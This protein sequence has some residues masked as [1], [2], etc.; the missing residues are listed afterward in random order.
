MLCEMDWF[1]FMIKK[2]NTETQTTPYVPNH[3][4]MFYKRNDWN[5]A[6][7]YVYW[8]VLASFFQEM[9]IKLQTTY[10]K[11]ISKCV[12]LIG[13]FWEANTYKYGKLLHRL[14]PSISVVS[15]RRRFVFS[16]TCLQNGTFWHIRLMGKEV[17]RFQGG[18]LPIISTCAKS[19]D[20][21]SVFTWYRWHTVFSIVSL[22]GNMTK[23]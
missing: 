4:I 6:I 1:L 12:L 11:Y 7:C 18:L 15:F 16:F 14:G 10:Q 23:H 20:V 8:C 17:D 2:T 5:K 3:T 9:S 19:N 22:I 21:L 13:G